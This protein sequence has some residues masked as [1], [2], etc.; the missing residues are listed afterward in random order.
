MT[1]QSPPRQP[2]VAE[3]VAGR[4]RSAIARGRLR[5]GDHLLP[6]TDLI[7][8]LS[9]SRPTLRE[10]LR[11]LESQRLVAI[12]RG[13]RGG[14]TVCAPSVEEAARSAGVVL[15][16]EGATLCDIFEARALIEVG[17]IGELARMAVEEA[18]VPADL[19][20]LRAMIREEATTVDDRHEFTSRAVQFHIALVDATENRATSLL[21]RMLVGI[22]ERH[23]R[24]AAA[25][26]AD[27]ERLAE[28]FRRAHRVHVDIIDAISAGEVDIAVDLWRRHNR[29]SWR[30]LERH[31]IATSLDLY[32]R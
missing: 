24:S 1:E 25:A 32:V 12:G 15:Q 11:I 5:P 4:I 3:Q 30:A 18:G 27:N 10:A 22:S 17:A 13:A 9:V 2:K 20:R 28:R 7:A 23:A 19:E 6:E 31:G 16:I 21:Y 14:A 8:R 29:A 26:T